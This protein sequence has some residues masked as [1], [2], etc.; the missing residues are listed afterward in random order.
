MQNN[1]RCGSHCWQWYVWASSSPVSSQHGSHPQCHL[2]SVTDV[3]YKMCAYF[4]VKLL[5][6]V[7]CPHIWSPPLISDFGQTFSHNTA[8]TTRKTDTYGRILVWCEF[9]PKHRLAKE[10][11]CVSCSLCVW[12]SN[13]KLWLINCHSMWMWSKFITLLNDL[14]SYMCIF[15]D[16]FFFSK[17]ACVY[18]SRTFVQKRFMHEIRLFADHENTS[19]TH[20]LTL[21]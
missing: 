17:H 14:F 2:P 20:F 4:F 9:L 13:V 8:K 5:I 21:K 11:L 6:V 15:K 10:M 19:Q 1:Y 16:Y 12:V 3:G 7:L 18:L